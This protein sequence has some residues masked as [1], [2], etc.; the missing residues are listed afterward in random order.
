M[1]LTMRTNLAMR[2]LMA[3][4]VNDGRMVRRAGIA[5]VVNASENHLAQVVHLLASEGYIVTTRGRAGGIVLAHRPEAISIGEVFR[6]F[7][8]HVPFAECFA[9]TENT[10]PLTETC[11]LR[12]AL[13]AAVEA[14]YGVLDDLTLA[15][16]VA[17]NGGLEALL[18]MPD[19]DMIL[20]KAGCAAGRLN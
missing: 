17:D 9:E 10:C 5:K 14:F 15:D 3:C 18:H 11:R 7:E 16:L 12:V 2:V 19:P 20:P 4:A 1:R 13:H 6:H 8:A